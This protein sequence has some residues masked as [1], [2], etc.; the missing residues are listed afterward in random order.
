MIMEDKTKHIVKEILELK[1]EKQTLKTKL[2]IQK[3]QQKL[4]EFKD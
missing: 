1:Q 2:K 3:L 4:D